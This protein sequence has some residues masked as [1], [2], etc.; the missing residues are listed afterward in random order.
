LALNRAIYPS[1]TGCSLNWSGHEKEP[2]SLVFY[3]EL[4]SSYKL[5]NRTDFESGN[6]TF[7]FECTETPVNGNVL[8]QTFT[9]EEFEEVPAKTGFYKM[10]AKSLIKK[11]TNSAERE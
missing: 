6:I 8:K 3:N 10:A 11:S 2:L 1:L 7:T 9:L 4:V 5:Y